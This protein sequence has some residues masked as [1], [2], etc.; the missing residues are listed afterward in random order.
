LA[1][2]KISAIMKSLSLL[3]DDGFEPVGFNFYIPLLEL[4][5]IVERSMGFLKA[6][7]AHVT[8]SRMGIFL[9]QVSQCCRG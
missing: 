9:E 1:I 4:F 2:P 6:C 7:F 3:L 5:S 8:I